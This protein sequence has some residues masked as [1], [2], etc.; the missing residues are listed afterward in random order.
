[1]CIFLITQ[2]IYETCIPYITSKI[3][4]YLDWWIWIITRNFD[5][6]YK[7]IYLS[8]HFYL[9]ICA[10]FLFM[11]NSLCTY[12]SAS[13]FLNIYLHQ[14]L[15][16]HIYLLIYQPI[17]LSLSISIYYLHVYLSDYLSL[18]ISQNQPCYVILFIHTF[19]NISK[20]FSHSW[21]L[22]LLITSHHRMFVI[23]LSQFV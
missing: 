20:S 10:F 6:S 7:I 16:C 1:M 21:Y 22:I 9:Q 2:L 12:L 13:L 5:L 23:S 8:V 3:C 17:C 15:S 14:I 19:T 11:S 18:F 4:I